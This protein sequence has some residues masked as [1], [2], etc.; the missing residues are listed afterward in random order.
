MNVMMDADVMAADVDVMVADADVMAMHGQGGPVVR[1]MMSNG[2]ILACPRR[3]ADKM[4]TVKAAL[5]DANRGNQDDTVDDIVPLSAVSPEIVRAIVEYCAFLVCHDASDQAELD[6]FGDAFFDRNK[7]HIVE[8]AA[9]ANFLNC[10][11]LVDAACKRIAHMIDNMT[12]EE[13][14]AFFHVD[15]DMTDEEIKAQKKANAWC[16]EYKE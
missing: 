15:Q 12:T 8:I 14:Q 1:L 9:Q 2:E 3:V 11:A 5:E 6:V 7:D 4:L 16:I 10:P 13:M